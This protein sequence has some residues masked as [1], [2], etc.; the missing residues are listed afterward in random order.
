MAKM[1]LHGTRLARDFR[2]RTFAAGLCCL[3]ALAPPL[4]AQ[5]LPAPAL[6]PATG[7]FEEIIPEAR[8]VVFRFMEAM[9]TPG[10]SV[11]VGMDGDIVWAQGFGYADL[12]NKVAAW[13]ATKFRIAS[14]SK[15]VTAAALGKLMEEGR[16]DLDAPIQAYVPSF[17]KKRWPI[18]TRLLAGHLA[19]IRHYRGSENLSSTHYED[20]LDAIEIFSGDPLVHEPGSAYLYSSYGWNLISAVIQGAAGVPFLDYMRRVVFEP[21]DMDETVAEHVDSLIYHRAR[22]YWRTDDGRIINAPYVDLSNKWA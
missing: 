6:A 1:C 7:A 2:S 22:F 14:I 19:G 17:P 10:L 9:G 8:E 4:P 12:E 20:V 3:V 15:P 16:L 13:P 21:L 18:T 11:A 5:E